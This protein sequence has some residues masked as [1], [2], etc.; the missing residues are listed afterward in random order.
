MILERF[1]RDEILNGKICLMD[2][3]TKK[4]INLSAPTVHLMV[5]FVEAFFKATG[6]K[7]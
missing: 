6:K 3:N 2:Q 4:K 5:Q 7:I 1:L